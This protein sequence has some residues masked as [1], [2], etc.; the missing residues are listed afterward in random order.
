M[1]LHLED[2][3]K[4]FG[5]EKTS[6]ERTGRIFIVDGHD[7]VGYRIVDQL[8]YLDYPMIR[9]RVRNTDDFQEKRWDQNEYIIEKVTFDWVDGSTY[10]AT[11]GVSRRSLL[12]LRST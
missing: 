7:V 11:L 2:L 10:D 9:V 1:K 12:P 8:V 5:V 4:C 3:K 6:L